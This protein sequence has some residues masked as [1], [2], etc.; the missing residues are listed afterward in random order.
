[1]IEQTLGDSAHGLRIKFTVTEEP[2]I[3]RNASSLSKW[4]VGMI[5]KKAG[6]ASQAPTPRV[7]TAGAGA[8]IVRAPLVD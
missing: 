3:A 7:A 6:R 8:S 4:E 5:E 2:E 1:M